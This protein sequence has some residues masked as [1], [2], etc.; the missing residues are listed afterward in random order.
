M[1]VKNN[2]WLVLFFLSTYL[3]I[4]LSTYL[5]S[6]GFKLDE[7]KPKIITPNGDHRN[8]ILII[9]CTDETSGGVQIT[10]RILTLNG[11]FVIDMHVNNIS[12]PYNP[13]ITWD[14][15]KD[16]KTVPSGIYIYQIEA[17]DKVFNGTVVVAK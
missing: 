12:D 8:D 6:D 15:K 16:G 13:L 3:P 17:E 7:T 5:R 14:G 10:A 11:A 4:Y 9:K 1:L 2:R